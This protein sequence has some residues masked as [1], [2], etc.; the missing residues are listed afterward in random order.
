MTPANPDLAFYWFVLFPIALFIGL[1]LTITAFVG[2][3]ALCHW[4]TFN[5]FPNR[6]E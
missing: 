3:R 6:G 4:V 5:P 1:P 2:V